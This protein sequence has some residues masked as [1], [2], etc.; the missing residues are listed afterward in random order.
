[1]K[2]RIQCVLTPWNPGFTAPGRGSDSGSTV[3]GH[4]RGTGSG[5]PVRCLPATTAITPWPE[6]SRLLI[7]Y[8]DRM[9]VRAE[10]YRQAK[11]QFSRSLS[12]PYRASVFF[13]L[14]SLDHLIAMTDLEV[15]G[16][17]KALA[18]LRRFGSDGALASAEQASD[19]LD[20]IRDVS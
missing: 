2:P 20:A 18:A 9:A 19:L 13:E 8:W 15:T 17:D 11:E 1:M 12:G 14:L 16:T 7:G 4:G 5:T 3:G 6:T 10:S